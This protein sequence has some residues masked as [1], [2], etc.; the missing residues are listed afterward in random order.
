MTSQL[1]KPATRRKIQNFIRLAQL[2]GVI[3]TGVFVIW[4]FTTYPK[5]IIAGGVVIVIIALMAAVAIIAQAKAA[6]RTMPTVE[7]W[8]A[9][10]Q[11]LRDEE[12]QAEKEQT[13]DQSD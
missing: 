9:R 5:Q 7:E 4:F 2:A 3:G 12:E 8:N 13:A 6:D 11:T 10:A 1:L